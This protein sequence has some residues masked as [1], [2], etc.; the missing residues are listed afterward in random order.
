MHSQF[1]LHRDVKP[2]NAAS[3]AEKVPNSEYP[4]SLQDHAYL[5]GKKD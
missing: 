3:G 4:V 5:L 1:Y 2:D